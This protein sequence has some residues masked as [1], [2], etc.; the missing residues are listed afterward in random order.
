MAM[1]IPDLSRY[2]TAT[3]AGEVGGGVGR[4]IGGMVETYQKDK[5]AKDTKSKIDQ[6][7]MA[8]NNPNDNTIFSGIKGSLRTEKLARLLLPL[9]P[10]LSKQYSLKANKEKSDEEQIARN[11][12][13]MKAGEGIA[14]TREEP[15][16]GLDAVDAEIKLIE[17]RLNEMK[18]LPKPTEGIDLNTNVNRYEVPV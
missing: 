15:V 6:Y 9:D 16:E 8:Y 2:N 5:E 18:S 4:F 12:E 14:S 11:T 7:L 3:Q 13:V 17:T 1:D 10:E